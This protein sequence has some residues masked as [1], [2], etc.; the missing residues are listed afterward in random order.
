LLEE[1]FTS[2][3]HRFTPTTGSLE[4]ES[5]VTSSSHCFNLYL[6]FVIL[7]YYNYKPNATQLYQMFSLR[8]L[9]HLDEV[10]RKAMI[11]RQLR[12]EGTT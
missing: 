2:F 9:H 11:I 12:M 8:F 7:N 6:D 1:G 4:N 10:R 5:P 3:I